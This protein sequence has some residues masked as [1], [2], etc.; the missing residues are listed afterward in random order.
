M[1]VDFNNKLGEWAREVLQKNG[2]TSLRA[3]ESRSR[4]AY[5]TIKNLLDGK[6]VSEA[7]II[8]FA[9]TFGEDIAA[10]LRLAGYN[11]IAGIFDHPKP[12]TSWLVKE[13]RSPYG[14]DPE[15]DLS[16]ILRLFKEIFQ[17][18]PPGRPS[19]AYKQRL[20]LQ[21]E[22]DLILL[23]ERRGRAD[24]PELR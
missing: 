18:L 9:H 2:V 12:R 19:E 22:T 24:E 5:S 13:T 21:A 16:D 10:A 7:I 6:V 8:R 23:G 15:S 17:S 20:R 11:D 3:A 1:P 14:E 4:I